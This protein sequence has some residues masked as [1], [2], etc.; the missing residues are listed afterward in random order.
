[1]LM[2]MILWLMITM[3]ILLKKVL[4][5]LLRQACDPLR[6]CV[7]ENYLKVLHDHIIWCCSPFNEVHYRLNNWAYFIALDILTFEFNKCW[8]WTSF[9]EQHYW[10]LMSSPSKWCA[11]MLQQSKKLLDFEE[12]FEWRLWDT[13]E[14]GGE[15]NFF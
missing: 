10:F 2:M 1:M 9:C 7:F 14:K 13:H 15:Q 5:S 4:F 8:M 3:T 6:I 11:L 12:T